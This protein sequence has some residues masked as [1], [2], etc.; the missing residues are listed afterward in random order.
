MTATPAPYN[1]DQ[2]LLIDCVR[3]HATPA[4]ATPAK[5]CALTTRHGETPLVRA[6]NAS[7]SARVN[8]CHGSSRS[9]SKSVALRTDRDP[10]LSFTHTLRS[11]LPSVKRRQYT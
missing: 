1:A 8:R 5:A 10:G 6:R 3:S 2:K 7:A 4:Q 9:S 11:S